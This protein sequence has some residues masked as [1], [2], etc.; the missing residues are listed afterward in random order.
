MGARHPVVRRGS[1][2]LMRAG[3]AIRMAHLRTNSSVLI[4]Q[5]Y[6]LPWLPLRI[7]CEACDLAVAQP[8]NGHY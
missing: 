1:R 8:T 6:E 3:G 4:P 7:Q 2:G 5:C